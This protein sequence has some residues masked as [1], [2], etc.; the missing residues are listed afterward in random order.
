MQSYEDT[1]RTGKAVSPRKLADDY[2]GSLTEAFSPSAAPASPRVRLTSRE[3]AWAVADARMQ[4][5]QPASARK[6]LGIIG[7]HDPITDKAPPG[8]AAALAAAAASS[9]SPSAAPAGAGDAAAGARGTSRSP[10]EM[11]AQM[12]ASHWTLAPPTSESPFATSPRRAA[13]LQVPSPAPVPFEELNAQSRRRK[14]DLY[15][16][17]WSPA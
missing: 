11:R 6:L 7:T 8:R 16:S 14:A 1:R 13:A 10:A 9:A 2:A 15:T 5:S 3:E 4:Q 12:L 17:S